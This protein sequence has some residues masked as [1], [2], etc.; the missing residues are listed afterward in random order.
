VKYFGIIGGAIGTVLCLIGTA[1][2]LIDLIHA[3]SALGY[4]LG[5]G[6]SVMIVILLLGT[7]NILKRTGPIHKM[8]YPTWWIAVIV[9]AVSL[10]V[11]TH[12]IFLKDAIAGSSVFNAIVET[13]IACAAILILGGSPAYLSHLIPIRMDSND[14][15]PE[16]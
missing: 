10:W 5:V 8:L 11:F 14:S 6:M 7:K 13:L 15:E 2:G 9:V 12:K 3:S 1:V 16:E 4:M